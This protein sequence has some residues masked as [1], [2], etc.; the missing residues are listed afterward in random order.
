M[1]EFSRFRIAS[2]GNLTTEGLS[3][4]R[5]TIES[6]AMFVRAGAVRVVFRHLDTSDGRE[7]TPSN[8][9]GTH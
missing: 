4:C 1:Q 5:Q 3:D 6:D 7:S 8:A 9:E 2:G